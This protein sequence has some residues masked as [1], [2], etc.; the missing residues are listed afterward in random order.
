MPLFKL[1]GMVFLF[2]ASLFWGW[3]KSALLKRR[4]R[5][6]YL[7][8]LALKTFAETIRVE[9][10]ELKI[11]CPK[12]FNFEGAKCEGEIPVFSE[13]FFSVEDINSFLEFFSLCGMA[14]TRT[15]YEKTL[16]FAQRVEQKCLDAEKLCRENSKTY[17]SIGLL[18]GVGLCIFFL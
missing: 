12:I 8:S 5:A 3:Y 16:A 6:L 2:S 4:A 13:D 17:M 14:D 7:M 18:G 15:E 9:Q 10:S 1:L 11:L